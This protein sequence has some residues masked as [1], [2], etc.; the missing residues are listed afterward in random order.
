M[1]PFTFS[2]VMCLAVVYVPSILQP[3]RKCCG[4]LLVRDLLSDKNSDESPQSL[5]SF[6]MVEHLELYKF[7]KLPNQRTHLEMDYSTCK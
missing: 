3:K 6:D 4:P 5:A 7:M 2:I 1:T